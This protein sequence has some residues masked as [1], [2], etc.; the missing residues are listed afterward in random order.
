MV[1]GAKNPTSTNRPHHSALASRKKP[2][3][4]HPYRRYPRK[5]LYRARYY[6]AELGRF[7][8]RDLVGYID[9]FNLYRASFV[10]KGVDPSG[11]I[12]ISVHSDKWAKVGCGLRNEISWRFE[13]DTA[14][15]PCPDGGY[16]V[17]KV[18]VRCE[19]IKCPCDVC[20]FQSPTQPDK[21]FYEAWPV[22]SNRISP[23][24]GIVATDTD[25]HTIDRGTCGNYSARG[26]IRYFCR[27][28]TGNLGEPGLPGTDSGGLW[29]LGREYKAGDCTVSG[30]TLPSTDDPNDVKDWWEE[31][32]EGPAFRFHS[33]TWQCCDFAR[34]FTDFDHLPR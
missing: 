23:Y 19:I 12:R 9:G 21:V 18:E 20:S 25:A 15:N 30:V 10:P 27:S 33:G 3:Q 7:V 34:K 32:V 2:T 17:Q 16:L 28:Q 31:P 6:H 13:L 1:T 29:E 11:R 4:T 8:S 24:A 22:R 26:E 5:R 14:P